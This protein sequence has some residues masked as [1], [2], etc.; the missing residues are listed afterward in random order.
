MASSLCS[1]FIYSSLQ[2]TTPKL[3]Q[4]RTETDQSTQPESRQFTKPEFRWNEALPFLQAALNSSTNASTGY[5]PHKLMYG[6]ELRQPSQMLRQAFATEQDFTIRLDA[7][8]S[9]SYAAMAMKNY[10]DKTY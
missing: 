10:Y 7:E 1:K 5:S 6:V 3:T 8:R 9:L 4:K 2:P